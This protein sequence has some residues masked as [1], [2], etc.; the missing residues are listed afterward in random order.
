VEFLDPRGIL[1]NLLIFFFFEVLGLHSGLTC[2]GQALYRMSHA[3]ALFALVV[4]ELGLTFCFM[5]LLFYV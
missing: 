5:I 3:P 4:L 1:F 2:A